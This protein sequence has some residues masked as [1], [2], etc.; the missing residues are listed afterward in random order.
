MPNAKGILVTLLA[1]LA[2]GYAAYRV[3]VGRGEKAGEA[4]FRGALTETWLLQTVKRHYYSAIQAEKSAVLAD[5]DEL[6]TEFAAAAGAAAGNLEES[7]AAL[8]SSFEARSGVSEAAAL[9]DFEGCWREMR[10]LDKDILA[11]AVQ[12]TNLKASRLSHGP[13]L[14]ALAAFDQAAAALLAAET[15]NPEIESLRRYA[16]RA[17]LALWRAQ[18]LHSPHIDE[19]EP[20]RMAGLDDRLAQLE[21]DAS[22]DLK[23]MALRTSPGGRPALQTATAAAARHAELTAEIAVLS[24]QNSNLVSLQLSLGHKRRLAAQCGDQLQ[25]L[26]EQVNARS[27]KAVR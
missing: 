14:E 26:I 21:R 17:A 8:K 22:D 19:A 24:R 27:L 25:A 15:G 9:K 5:T 20:A 4:V 12:N 13:A 18:A 7:L 1:L 23:A 16:E 2:I 6:S 11:L 3:G 10:A